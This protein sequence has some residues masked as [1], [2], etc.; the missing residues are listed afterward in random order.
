[1]LHNN[2]ICSVSKALAKHD[3]HIFTYIVSFTDTQSPQH[4]AHPIPTL[5][6]TLFN[7]KGLDLTLFKE[8]QFMI[9]KLLP[10]TSR[11]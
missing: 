10:T 7:V 2:R 4:K 1:M 6:P 8:F 3:K 5:I 9:G 11:T